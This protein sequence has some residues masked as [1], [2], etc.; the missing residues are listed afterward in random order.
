MNKF[1]R[2]AL[3]RRIK[4]QRGQLQEQTISPDDVIDLGRA[5]RGQSFGRGSAIP[6]DK[7][8]HGDLVIDGKVAGRLSNYIH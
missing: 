7:H 8:K 5:K 1:R 2:S 3:D 6:R 4:R